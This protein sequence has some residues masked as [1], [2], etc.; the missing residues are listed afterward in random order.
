MLNQLMW[1]L[2]GHAHYETVAQINLLILEASG[3]QQQ[4]VCS[5]L[6]N[7]YSTLALPPQSYLQAAALGAAWQLDSGRANIGHIGHSKRGNGSAHG[8]ADWDLTAKSHG[9][10]VVRAAV[11]APAA[12]ACSS[13][14][15]SSS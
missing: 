1:H 13:S 3:L 8:G 6:G 12:P 11:A 7:A 10:V 4:A 14:S 5:V 9:Y 2:Q 15:S